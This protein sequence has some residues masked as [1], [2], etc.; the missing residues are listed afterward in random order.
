MGTQTCVVLA[1]GLGTRLRGAVPDLPKCLAPV[2]DRP[3][4]QLQLHALQALGVQR[5]VLSL[6]HMADK[7]L[8][9]KTGFGLVV[10]VDSVV[11][12]QA[13]GTGGAV[14]FAM[15]E[16]GVEE[17]LVVNGDTFLEADLSAMLQPL[18]AAGGEL[19]R[20]AT[21]A[22]DDRARYGGVK[23]EGGTVTGFEEK[24]HQGPGLINAGLYRV[25]LDAFG[26]RG[27]GEPFSM[28]TAV[29]PGLLPGGHLRGT[30]LDG[31]FIDIGIPADYQR[32]CERHTRR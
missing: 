13:L 2:G 18:D 1:G 24:G 22:V 6:G 27:S 4:L 11:E 9:A 30:V 25:H 16:S 23:L 10:P 26:G 21:I 7:V 12:R 14:L 19:F 28:E 31:S 29:M 5:F 3:F 32:F 17:A 15:R 8:Q 20:M